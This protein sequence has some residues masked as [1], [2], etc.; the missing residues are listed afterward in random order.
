[1]VINESTIQVDWERPFTWDDLPITNYTVEVFNQTDDMLSTSII[2]PQELS[3][4]ITR[5]TPPSCTNLTFLVRAINSV[6]PSL[7]GI[8]HGAFPFSKLALNN[9]E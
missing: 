4:S 2:S 1:M 9:I 8:T 6:G 3:Y 5:T 7:P